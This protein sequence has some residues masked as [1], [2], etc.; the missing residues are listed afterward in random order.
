MSSSAPLPESGCGLQDSE[1]AAPAVHHQQGRPVCLPLHLPRSQV[2]APCPNKDDIP[3]YCCRYEKCTNANSASPWCATVT[4][5]DGV[6][7]TNKLVI[8]Y[9]VKF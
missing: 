2:P 6:V 7:I 4:N 9:N 1:Q 8:A 3:R 5:T